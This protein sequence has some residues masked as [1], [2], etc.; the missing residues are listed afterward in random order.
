MFRWFMDTFPVS[1]KFLTYFPYQLLILTFF[2][3]FHAKEW[4][5]SLEMKNLQHFVPFERCKMSARKNREEISMILFEEGK[6]LKFLAKIST[7]EWK[8]WLTLNI[9][10]FRKKNLCCKSETCY[11]LESTN[12]LKMT[13]NNLSILKWSH[14]SPNKT[15]F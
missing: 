8:S 2:T 11:S 15:K 13:Q 1:D 14:H 9:N 12:I 4:K 3:Q 7:L 5:F 10:N 6:K